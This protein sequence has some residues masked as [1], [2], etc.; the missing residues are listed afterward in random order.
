[1]SE[2]QRRKAAN[3]ALFR[4]V[5]EQISSL[6]SRLALT[7]PEPL[8]IIC[9]C[10]RLTCMQGINVPFDVYEQVR[11]DAVLFLVCPSHEDPQVEDVVDT[12]SDYLIV[13]K[14]AGEPA[15]VA[16]DTDPRG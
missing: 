4:E 10:D 8:H 11:R 6:S 12:G 1:M 15:A 3:E 13:R 9:E 2:T 14:R 7:Q 5:N 16:R